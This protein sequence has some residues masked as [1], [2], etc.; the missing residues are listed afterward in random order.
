MFYA[1]SAKEARARY[2]SL[3]GFEE[4]ADTEPIAADRFTAGSTVVATRQEKPVGFAIVQRIDAVAH[5]V[6]ISV[7]PESSDENVGTSLLEKQNKPQ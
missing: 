7:V 1:R 3:S 5:L 4:F 2:R 6:N